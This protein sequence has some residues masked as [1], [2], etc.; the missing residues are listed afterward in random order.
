MNNINEI[1]KL[2][3]EIL[4]SNKTLEEGLEVINSFFMDLQIK[5]I[6]NQNELKFNFFRT[7]SMFDFDDE[8]KFNIAGTFMR[9]F[10]FLES[11]KKQIDLKSLML[12]YYKEIINRTKELED[13]IEWLWPD[14]FKYQTSLINIIETDV[15]N[16]V[17]GYQ[18]MK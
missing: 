15:K 4:S 1:V 13:S 3:D 17:I 11:L 10:L 5:T 12:E 14:S 8:K 16:N 9:Y 18:D 6:E 2:I 7:M